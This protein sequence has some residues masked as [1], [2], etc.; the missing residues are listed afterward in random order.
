MTKTR[1]LSEEW[2]PCPPGT[3]SSMAGDE[4]SRQRRQFVVRAGSAVGA[5]AITTGIGW[6]ALRKDGQPAD[7]VY[8]GIACSRVRALAPQMMMGKLDSELS[9]QIMAHL[10]LCEDCRALVESMRPKSAS[11]NQLHR[12]NMAACQCSGCRRN[13]L[14]TSLTKTTSEVRAN[15]A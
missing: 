12:E 6:F 5:I 15:L 8:A 9:A 7:P 4:R 1:Q 13:Q 14:S 2:T 11:A 3:L 10:E